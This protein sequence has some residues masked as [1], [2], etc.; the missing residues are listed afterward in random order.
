MNTP[1]PC[2]S[3]KSYESCCQRYHTGEPAENAL[4]LMRSRYAAYALNL[5]DYLIQTT[6]PNNSSYTTDLTA[7]KKTIDEMSRTT[8]FAGKRTFK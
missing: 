3:G 6:H 8:Q 1:C 4:K 5:S 7:W 2:H